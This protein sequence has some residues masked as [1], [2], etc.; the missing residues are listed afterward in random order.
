MVRMVRHDQQARNQD[1]TLQTQSTISYRDITI[2]GAVDWA[3]DSTDQHTIRVNRAA[4]SNAKPP[5]KATQISNAA[6]FLN[7]L[8]IK[9]GT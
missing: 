6:S 7:N 3:T 2:I 4:L 1:P 5:P 9:I 8:E